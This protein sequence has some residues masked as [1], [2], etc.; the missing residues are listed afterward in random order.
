MANATATRSTGEVAEL[1]GVSEVWLQNLFR[2]GKMKKPPK[3]GHRLAWSEE[4]IEQA[5]RC[6]RNSRA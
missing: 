1:L 6:L 3:V 5:R 2:Y 4:H